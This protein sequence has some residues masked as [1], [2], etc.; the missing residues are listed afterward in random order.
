MPR[1]I[2]GA[3]FLTSKERQALHE[4][5][6]L[7]KAGEASY[8]T[9]TSSG[10]SWRTIYWPQIKQACAN[11]ITFVAALWN[12]LYN[13]S[14]YGVLYWA[15]MLVNLVLG[16]SPDHKDTQAGAVTILLT[17]IPYAAAAVFQTLFSWHSQRQQEKRWHVA[18]AYTAAGACMFLLPVVVAHSNMVGFVFFTLTTCIVFAPLSVSDSYLM[19]LLGAARGVGGAIEN[20]LAVLGGFVGPYIIGH[21]KDSTGSYYPALYVMGASL[22]A[23]AVPVVLY[24]SHWSEVKAMPNMGALPTSVVS[25]GGSDT[26]ASGV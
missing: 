15:P 21:I 4:V 3:T 2:E 17:A 9:G 19:Q 5:M 14:Y 8:G 7:Q 23:A 12:F 16:R 25:G 24:N 10:S 22:C 13:I 1:S 20:A 11:P 26:M 6:T 18:V